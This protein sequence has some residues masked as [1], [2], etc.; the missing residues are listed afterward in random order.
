MNLGNLQDKSQKMKAEDNKKRK[1]Q[2]SF[3]QHQAVFIRLY[4]H[5]PPRLIRLGVNIGKVKV[6]HNGMCCW[7][8]NNE[9]GII[10]LIAKEVYE[11]REFRSIIINMRLPGQH[12]AESLRTMAFGKTEPELRKGSGGIRDEN[13]ESAMLK[14]NRITWME[15][16]DIL[17][18]HVEVT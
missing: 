1:Q 17:M 7:V 9:E 8:N 15:A 10:C 11:H 4:N 5:A 6:N 3:T 16:W 12:D 2:F 13:V 18:T 14:V